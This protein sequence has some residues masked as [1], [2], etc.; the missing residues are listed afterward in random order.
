MDGIVGLFFLL[1]KRRFLAFERIFCI[2]VFVNLFASSC[3]HNNLCIEPKIV[4]LSVSFVQPDTAKIFKDTILRNANVIFGKPINYLVNINKTGRFQMPLSQSEDSVLFFFQADSLN[5][6][7]ETI[8]T[9][10]LKYVRKISFISSACGY[11]TFFSLRNVNYTK[12]V[13]DSAMIINAEVNN[14]V[15]SEHLQFVIKP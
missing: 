3:K 11:E 7:P 2:C 9:I 10:S 15:K 14:N 8:D 6:M 4:R 5:I 1:E 13:I 12:H